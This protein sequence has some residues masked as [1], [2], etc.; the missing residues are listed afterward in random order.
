M[1]SL[2]TVSQ[3]YDETGKDEQYQRDQQELSYR[4][5]Q[6]TQRVV[7]V[8]CC[9]DEREPDPDRRWDKCEQKK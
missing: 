7:R 2:P 3:P 4:M 5:G 6:G 9:V 8:P 1:A